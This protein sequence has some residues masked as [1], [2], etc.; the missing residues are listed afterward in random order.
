M[1]KMSEKKIRVAIVGAGAIAETAHMPAYLCNPYAEIV[2]IV[3]TNSEQLARTAKKF[4]VKKTFNSVDD[5]LSEMKIDAMS[6]CTPPDTHAE[7]ALKGLQHGA[8]I[9]C[10]K[11]LT[12]D[13]DSGKKMVAASKAAGKILTV[14]FHR[15][16]IPTYQK[17]QKQIL[18]GS[19]GHVYCV[20]D[21]FIEPNPLYT[22]T[23][24]TWFFKPNVGGVLFDIAPHVFDML[25]FMFNDFP[26][27]IS[28]RGSTYLDLPVEDYCVFV[29]E[30]SGGR[31]GIGTASWLSNNVTQSMNIFG[32]AQ[33]LQVSPNFFMKESSN[34]FRE[35]AMLRAAGQSLLSMKF[36]NLPLT[37]I[38][39]VDAYQLEIDQFI[40]HIR[41]N[42]ISPES[43]L[44]GFSVVLTANAAKASI[45]KGCRIE[46]P[47]PS[48]S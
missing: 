3:D 41:K 9:L 46:I 26:V 39:R 40:D 5:L 24:S 15:R 10:E 32:T 48:Q 16:F 35:I 4:N 8:H 21:H 17:A 30:Y 37:N 33:N 36:P 13:T 29:L 11:P 19:L 34:E 44:N 7:I 47:N 27:A 6:I 2:A 20:V 25:N 38:K 31:I 22:Y 28:A 14:G 18:N 45:E 1:Q 12:T 23:K 42:M 43:A